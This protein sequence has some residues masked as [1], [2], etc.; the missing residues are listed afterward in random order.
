MASLLRARI[1]ARFDTTAGVTQ[2]R[3]TKKKNMGLSKTHSMIIKRCKKLNL[4]GLRVAEQRGQRLWPSGPQASGF[5]VAPS[6]RD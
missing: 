1:S 2:K 6:E 5:V 4:E 3:A